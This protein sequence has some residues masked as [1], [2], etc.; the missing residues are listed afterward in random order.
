MYYVYTCI[1]ATI[2][3]TPLNITTF[4]NMPVKLRCTVKTNVQSN[5]KLIWM[6]GDE[7]VTGNGYSIESTLFDIINNTQNHFLT[8]HKASPGDYTCILISTTREV[9]DSKT[10]HVVTESELVISVFDSLINLYYHSR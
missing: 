6:K 4:E 9:I 10:Q 5:Y 2:L 3:P 7:F 8:I 1:D